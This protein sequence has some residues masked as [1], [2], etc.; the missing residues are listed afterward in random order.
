MNLDALVIG[1]MFLL[2]GLI[3]LAVRPKTYDRKS[4]TTAKFYVGV[5]I[6]LAVGILIVLWSLLKS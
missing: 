3:G 6:S 4:Y 1:L 5:Y 2:G